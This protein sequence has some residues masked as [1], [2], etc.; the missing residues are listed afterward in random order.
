MKVAVVIPWRPKAGRWIAHAFVREWYAKHFPEWDVV[1]HPG[2]V[3]GPFNLARARNRGVYFAAAERGADVMV[4]NDAD[5][6]PEAGPLLDAVR[7]AH[8]TGRTVLPY[9]EYRSLRDEGTDMHM[10]G[11][12]LDQCLFFKVDVA[13]SGIFVTTRDAWRL[14]DGQDE[15]FRGWGMEDFAWLVSHRVL[16]GD[17]P[18]RVNGKV[19]AFTHP[20]ELKEG[21]QYDANVARLA[22]Y[23]AAADAGDVDTVR[24]LSRGY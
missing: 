21:P 24:R 3:A 2:T 18:Q 15:A 11:I 10:R 6:I 17:E 4:V 5:T 12:A 23:I 9:T 7:T 22:R 20:P 1:E 16:V 8:A 14:T 13:T 19:Y